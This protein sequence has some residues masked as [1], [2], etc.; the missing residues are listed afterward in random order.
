MAIGNGLTEKELRV[1]LVGDVDV[2]KTSI[3]NR[4]KTG[5]FVEDAYQS[6]RSRFNV[7]DYMKH[8]SSEGK[9]AKVSLNSTIKVC[10]YG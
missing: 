9:E 6:S 5:Q 3:F 10:M 1:L 8:I 7:L 2:G 4:F